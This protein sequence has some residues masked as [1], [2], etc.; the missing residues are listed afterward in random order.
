MYAVGRIGSYITRGAYT[1]SAPF[2]PFGGVVDIIVVEQ[3]D[4]SFKSSPWYVRFGKFQGVLKTKEKVVNISV[5]GVEANFHM[6]LDHTGGAY[7]LR[8]V[9]DEEGESAFYP[10]LSGEEMDVQSHNRRPMKSKSC[11]YD[12]NQSNSVSHV[13]LS[14]GKIVARTSSRRSRILGLVFGRKSVKEDRLQNEEDGT[15]VVRANSLERAEIAADLLEVKWSTNLASGRHRKNNASRF[16]ASDTLNG[17]A[18]EDFRIHGQKQMDSLADE[19]SLDY[20]MS[21]E[22]TGSHDNET[23]N[24][25]PFGFQKPESSAEETGVEMSCLTTKHVIETL[26][27]SESGLEESDELN[28]EISRKITEPGVRDNADHNENAN[29]VDSEITV[30]N[31]QIPD[32]CPSKKLNEEHVF[33]EDVI[34]PCSGVS[35]E[36]IGADGLQSFVYSETSKS[37]GVGLDNSGE[38]AEETL[39]FSCEKGGEVCVHAETFHETAEPISKV[40]SLPETGFL[41]AKEP[42]NIQEFIGEGSCYDF[43]NDAKILESEGSFSSSIA[44]SIVTETYTQ[45][46][47]VD[48]LN[49]SIKEVKSRSICTISGFNNSIC[50]VQDEENVKDEDNTSKFQNSSVR[51]TD[52]PDFNGSCVSIEA[53]NISQSDGSDEEQFLFGNL[54]DFKPSDVKYTESISSGQEEKE[55][56]Y[57][58]TP[59]SIEAA[60]ESLDSDYESYTSPEIFFG[61]NLPNDIEDL[62]QK[63]G[64]LSS[65]INIPRSSKVSGTEVGRMVESLPNMWS[66]V[67]DV[68]AHDHHHSLGS[69]LDLNSTSSK[70]ALLRKDISSFTKSDVDKEHQLSQAQPATDDAQILKELTKVSADPAVGDLSK[71]IDA[72]SGSWRLW[73]FPFKRSRS[74]KD[75]PP[76]LDCS[77]SFDAENA[78]ES[79]SCTDGEKNVLKPKLNKKKVRAITPTSEQLAS[80]NLKEG[81]NTVTFTFSTAMLGKQQVDARIYLWRWDTRIVISDVDGTITK[82]DVL[83]QFMP[84]VGIDWSQTGVA[85]LFSA[86]KENGYQLLFLSARAISQAYHTRQFLF[87]LKQDGKALPD[88]PVVISPDGLFPS[89][90]REVIRRA[91]HEFKIACLKDIKA[92]FPADR[93]PFYAGFGNRDTDEFSYLKVGIPKGKIFIIN[94]KLQGEVAVNRRVDT[95]SYTSLHALVHGMFPPMSSSEQEDFNSWNY[96]KLPPPAIDV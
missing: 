78:L 18:D 71:A 3:Q 54:D 36:E 1:V 51:V 34:L 43:H 94:P 28:S 93:S 7:F 60:I 55:N 58:V 56:H 74:M 22:E 12:A 44:S 75:S 32:S 73:P 2:H 82:S 77:R 62:R 11:N 90:F 80:L 49:G 83:G 23:G 65:N 9:D 63:S 42:L 95:K 45:V 72:S 33:D 31:S 38:Q 70:W 35:V 19:N 27:S 67:D 64:I 68:D 86:I 87:N 81:S 79:T 17:E 4:G 76:A 50:Q 69:S 66:H 89:L 13:D 29:G 6:Y 59:K 26:T 41:V 48:S 40:N 88:G 20:L 37:S 21:H 39:Y 15:G 5:N 92:L 53:I 16:S 25:S 14:N 84:L 91:P 10:S 57:S 85:H 61:G 8:E 47:T 46:F 52:P 24:S 96:W 30:P